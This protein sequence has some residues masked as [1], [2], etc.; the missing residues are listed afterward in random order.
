MKKWLLLTLLF[1]LLALRPAA[2]DVLVLVHGYLGT[3][4]SWAEAGTLGR[5]AK[6]GYRLVGVLGYGAQGV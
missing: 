1:T 5:L 6:R 2:A 3:A 4:Q